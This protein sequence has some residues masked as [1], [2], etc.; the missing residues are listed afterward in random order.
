M[1]GPCPASGVRVYADEGDAAMGLRVVGLHLENCGKSSYTLQGRP[2]LQILDEDHQAV[3]GV[4]IVPGSEIA[5]GTGQDDTVR[6]LTLRPGERAEAGLVWRN[7]VEGFDGAAL[8][9][10][11]QAAGNPGA[12][13][14]GETGLDYYRDLAP[15]EEQRRAFEQQLALAERLGLRRPPLAPAACWWARMTLPST[16]WTLQSTAPTASACSWTA[17]KSRSQSPASRRRQRR[18][19]TV[20]QGPYRS[21]R[22]RHGAPV[23]S[24]HRMPSMIRRWSAFGR[25]VSGFSGGSNGFSPAHCRSVS[26]P[27]WVMPTVEQFPAHLPGHFAYTP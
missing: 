2:R 22:S 1:G 26:S 10:I 6:P 24:R 8:T 7:T 12:R 19:Y 20:D 18:L 15:R 27:R 21:G 17:A 25:P 23:R 3:E 13:A 11:E 4:R 5:T 16:N 14:I 9:E